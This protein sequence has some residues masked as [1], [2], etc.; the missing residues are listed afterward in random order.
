MDTCGKIKGTTIIAC[1]MSLR[2]AITVMAERLSDGTIVVLNA[3][4]IP[5]ETLKR[6]AEEFDRARVAGEKLNAA[7]QVPELPAIHTPMRPH[8]H[9]NDVLPYY[10]GKHHARVQWNQRKHNHHQKTGRR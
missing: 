10:K 1:D 6:M 8:T 7:L 5:A 3:E 9:R 4:T 2:P